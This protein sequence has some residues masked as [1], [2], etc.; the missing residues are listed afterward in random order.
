MLCKIHNP[1]LARLLSLQQDNGDNPAKNHELWHNNPGEMDCEITGH[2]H[3]RVWLTTNDIQLD[4]YKPP[5]IKLLVKLITTT[6]AVPWGNA[7]HMRY[8]TA[9]S[10]Y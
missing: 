8:Q 6:N 4:M 7:R 9:A 3:T 2:N 10:L 5:H 1:R